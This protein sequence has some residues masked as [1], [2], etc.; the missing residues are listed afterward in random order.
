V[1]PIAKPLM[2]KEEKQAVLEVL[3]SGI[4][5]QGPR[6]RAFEEAFELPIEWTD[7]R[8]DKHKT[9]VGRPVAMH[10]MRGISAHANGFQTARALHVLGW[11][12][13]TNADWLE[14]D[15]ATGKLRDEIAPPTD[16]AGGSFW[17][18]MALPK[19][20]FRSIPGKLESWNRGAYLV[21]GPGH[22]A[23][24]HTPRN[25][26][27]LLDRTRWLTGSRHPAEPKVSVPSLRG[28]IRRERYKNVKDL[29]DALKYGES[30]G[31]EDLSSGGMGEVQENLSRLPDEDLKAMA[32][33]LAS[34][35]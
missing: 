9:M 32:E 26:I 8:G 16:Q 1:I 28:L 21:L 6:V 18:W 14:I 12:L 19:G 7:F 23:E 15:A 13:S 25:S 31:Y 10:A 3:D 22:C 17:K 24:C 33:Y 29:H 27:M 2:G 35:E 5:A 20:E 4:I 30:L 11:S 34:L